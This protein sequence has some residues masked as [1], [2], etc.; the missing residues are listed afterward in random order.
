[1]RAR[2]NAALL[3]ALAISLTT[4]GCG[5][6][7][8][9]AGTGAAESG[10]STG[11][12]GNVA[13]GSGGGSEA[14]AG[15]DSTGTGTIQMAGGAGATNAGGDMGSAGS[16]SGT[17]GASGSGGSAGGAATGTGGSGGSPSTG[18]Q[19]A[20]A[21]AGIAVYTDPTNLSQLAW[22]GHGTFK[23]NATGGCEGNKAYEY[24]WNVQGYWDGFLL[25]LSK[26]VDASK[27]IAFTYSYKQGPSDPS[28]FFVRLHSGAKAC[29]AGCDVEVHSASADW[30]RETIPI[31]TF[32]KS[33]EVDVSNITAI[34]FGFSGPD[35]S[36]TLLL[37]S[38][39]FTQ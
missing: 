33:G 20:C 2:D 16:K 3:S 29:G 31:S 18:G 26:P 19:G 11:S 32:V 5:G 28:F 39:V 30:K 6:G 24:D 36:G 34:E 8:D 38:M 10:G 27:A 7:D 23:E 14:R 9:G 22:K 37:D 25:N 35:A 21:S 1:M 13:N 17:G 15:S 4:I 12:A